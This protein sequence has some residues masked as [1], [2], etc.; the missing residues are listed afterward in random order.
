MEHRWEHATA[1]SLRVQH[2]LYRE[3]DR[4][5][6]VK[7]LEVTPSKPGKHGSNKVL[8]KGDDLQTGRTWTGSYAVGDPV[9]VVHPHGSRHHVL[10]ATE[11]AVDLKDTESQETITVTSDQ[12]CLGSLSIEAVHQAITDGGEHSIKVTIF[13]PALYALSDLRPAGD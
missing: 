9:T 8:I 12:L 13:T 6:A 1:G 11:Q 10:D 4:P 2:C 3:G 7:I 5:P